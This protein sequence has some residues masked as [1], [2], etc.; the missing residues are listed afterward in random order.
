MSSEGAQIAIF[1]TPILP[2]TLS[3]MAST[4]IICKILNSKTKLKSPYSRLIFGLSLYD[5]IS[6]S[7]NIASTMPIPKEYGDLVFGAIGNSFTC[8]VQGTLFAFSVVCTTFYNAANY[9]N[10][11]GTLCWIDS[12]P[13]GSDTVKLVIWILSG[14]PLFLIFVVIVVLMGIITW[15]VWRQ[16]KKMDQ[17]RFFQSED[18]SPQSSIQLENHQSNSRNHH[19]RRHAR[20]RTRVRAVKTQANLYFWG[21]ILTYGPAFLYRLAESS[22][23]KGSVTPPLAF[24]LL[25][26]FFHP[27]QGVFNLIAHLQPRVSHLRRTRTRNNSTLHTHSTGSGNSGIVS[28]NKDKLSWLRAF[29][30][31]IQTY[32]DALDRNHGGN[33]RVKR[34]STRLI[35][36]ISITQPA[37]NYRTNHS[38]RFFTIA[39]DK[40]LGSTGSLSRVD[41]Y[42]INTDHQNSSKSS[43]DKGSSHAENN[44]KKEADSYS[45]SQEAP[46]PVSED[47]VEEGLVKYTTKLDNFE[48]EEASIV[49]ENLSTHELTKVDWEKVQISEDEDEVIDSNK[50]DTSQSM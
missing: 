31:A 38:S 2:G 22:F 9:I 1:A 36:S 34:R 14:I 42:S 49:Q 44:I 29:W 37:R 47:T 43:I 18:L 15:I 5:V 12:D 8:K 19:R 39:E 16:E 30:I 46:D 41:E 17:Y 26:R 40:A 28:N 48:E 10:Y 50:Y 45:G 25:S 3:F 23:E 24:I 20:H 7:C 21:F 35:S 11:A 13:R 32:D 4:T 33:P 27:L 6:S